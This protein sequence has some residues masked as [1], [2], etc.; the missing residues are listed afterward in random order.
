MAVRA[1]TIAHERYV[2]KTELRGSHT[3][4]GDM[5]PIPDYGHH[6]PIR[7]DKTGA[8]F[9]RRPLTACPP[10]GGSSEKLPVIRSPLSGGGT[11]ANHTGDG[12]PVCPTEAAPLSISP[13]AEP[14]H[15]PPPAPSLSPRR[16]IGVAIYCTKIPVVLFRKIYDKK[17]ALY[18]Y[19]SLNSAVNCRKRVTFSRSVDCLQCMAVTSI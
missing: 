11:G 6:R 14:P 17:V 7:T 18:K 1:P 19:R 4:G 13:P 16:N 3:P 8:C 10:S 12:Q 15:R 2:G 9:R 5:A